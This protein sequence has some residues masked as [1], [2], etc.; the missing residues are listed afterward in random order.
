MCS[1]LSVSSSAR[2]PNSDGVRRGSLYLGKD[3]SKGVEILGKGWDEARQ[4]NLGGT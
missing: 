1:V 4:H 2:G 3:H